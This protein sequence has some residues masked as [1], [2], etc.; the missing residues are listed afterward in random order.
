MDNPRKGRPK[1]V[2]D[3]KVKQDLIAENQHLKERL[4][5]L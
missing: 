4:E 1:K 3:K 2:L 5:Q